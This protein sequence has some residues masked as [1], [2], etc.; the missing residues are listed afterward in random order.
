MMRILNGFSSASNRCR[1]NPA[2]MAGSIQTRR[3]VRS[4]RAQV[5]PAVG[6]NRAWARVRRLAQVGGVGLVA[7][8]F[9]DRLVVGEA[10]ALGGAQRGG[11]RGA[12]LAGERLFFEGH[13]EFLFEG[14]RGAGAVEQL[15][16]PPG[17]E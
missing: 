5:G 10:T 6:L 7:L 1:L 11:Q 17:E 13:P 3:A 9:L 14:A 4:V 8:E 2:Q 16:T 12:Q 15:Q